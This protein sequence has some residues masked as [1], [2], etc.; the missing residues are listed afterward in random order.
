VESKL[1]ELERLSSRHR[2]AFESFEGKF[3][4]YEE[5]IPGVKPNPM[6]PPK[7]LNEM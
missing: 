6:P 3:Q 5:I 1:V 4:E 7:V 2:E